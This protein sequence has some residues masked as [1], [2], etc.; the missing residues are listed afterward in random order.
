MGSKLPLK[1]LERKA[2][3]TAVLIVSEL[4]KPCVTASC[5]N[6]NSPPQLISL[7]DDTDIATACSNVAV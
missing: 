4:T 3:L 5:N 6:L 7:P 1:N 2:R